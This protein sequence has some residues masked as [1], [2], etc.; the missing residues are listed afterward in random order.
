MIT[1]LAR[2]IAVVAT[3]LCMQGAALAQQGAA[4]EKK[5]FHYNEWTKGRF[6]EAVTVVNPG[7]WIFLAGVGSEA[8]KDG[9]ILHPGDFLAQCRY[10]YEKIRRILA[11]QGASLADVVKLTSYVTDIRDREG[12]NKCRTEAFAGLAVP[13]HTFLAISQLARPGMLFEVDVVAVTAR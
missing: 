13:A 10:A 4:F 5:H 6:A 12:L 2:A 11:S 3:A 1:T 7:K 9:S 8:E